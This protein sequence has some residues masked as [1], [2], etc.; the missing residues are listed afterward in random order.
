MSLALWP[1]TASEQAAHIDGLFTGLLVVTGLILL[2]VAG[3][4]LLFCIRYRRGTQ[5]KRGD[6][7]EF[8]RRDVELGW[9]AATLFLALF[10]FWWA[11]TL[12]LRAS[13]APPE[14]LEIHVV[15]KQWMWKARHPNGA[16]EIDALH[17]P[18][19]E[20]VRLVMTSQDVIHSFYVPAF[21]V[22]QD[23][24]PGRFTEMWFR[25]TR[26]GE[27]RLF[28]AEFCGTQHSRMGGMVT[29]M[30]PEDYA[31]WA[32][33]Q[34]QEQDLPGE[35]EALFT[36]LGCAGCHAPAS[37]VHAPVLQGVY[38]R[39]VHLADGR[40]VRAD[41]AYLRDSILQPQRDVVAGYAPIMPSFAGLVDEADLQRLVAYLQSL[42]GEAAR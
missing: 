37:A 16:R 19:G 18:R 26:T 34:P 35:G 41:Q 31:S 9:T 39:M 32:A 33:A 7:P 28:C 17:V 30:E 11:G 24:L 8:L 5:A 4:L 3:L 12:E 40:T 25:P 38:G 6:L 14:A 10:L 20:A 36:A 27:Y 1:A 23:V 2:L 15:A 13:M 22:K 21:R 42:R 29:V